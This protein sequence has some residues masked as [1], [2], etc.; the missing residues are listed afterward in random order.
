MNIPVELRKAILDND[1]V[2]FVGA[3][4]SYELTNTKNKPLK[5]WA[6]LV[7]CILEHLKIKGYEV[8]HLLPLIKRY[9]PIKVLDLIEHD[10]NLPKKEIYSFVKTFFELGD[11]NTLAIHKKIF[12]LSNK[13]ITT[14]YDTAFEEAVPQLRRNK[15]YKGKNY[16]LTTHK[17]KDS[18]LL[19]KLH[20]CSEDADSMVLFPTNYENLYENKERDAEHSLLVLK[21]IIL[22]KSILFIG[23]GLGDF[24][25]N[26]IFKEV[27]NLQ[28]EYNQKHFIITN[29]TL[30]SNLNFVTPIQIKA[31][32]EIDNIIDELISIKEKAKAEDTDEV[33]KL[34][35][36]LA[37]A[38]K[39]L[40]EPSNHSLKEELVKKNR[41]L[42]IEALKYFSKG[43]VFSISNEYL[44]ASSAYKSAI[45]LKPDYHEAFNNLGNALVNLGKS[46]SGKEAEGLYGQAITQYEK[47]I[48]LKPDYHE[49]FN[50]L[51][52][53]LGNLGKTK[54][55]KE[56][57][58]L[59]RQAI[60]KYENAITLKPDNHEAFN[61]LGN[62][63]GDLGKSKSG[64]EA[65]DLYRQAI[66]KIENAIALKPDFHEAFNNLGVALA[67]LGKSKSGKEAEDLY[68]QAITNYKKAIALKPDYHEAFINLGNAL[69]YLGQSKSGKEAE[70]LYRQSITKYDKAI[71]LKPDNHD[72]F[73]NL[74]TAL[75][76][77]GQ[78]KSDK[79]AED[80]Y[81]QA[82]A[83][84]EKAIEY[85]GSSYNLSCLYALRGDKN[86][87]LKYLAMSLSNNEIK[88][89][90]V[91]KDTDWSHYLYDK[92]FISVLNKFK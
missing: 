26:N 30:D 78:S 48:K 66:A 46:K 24:Q 84:Y 86:N 92:D 42:E 44:N 65:K 72:A 73:N 23:V 9:E 54:S 38:E 45:K 15:A 3:G 17:D 52:S 56:A 12:Q 63:L 80:L 55:G 19:F 8:E 51:G 33:K 25:I 90:F 16:E 41:L 49:A 71:A 83:E 43:I 76:Y 20:G 70:D 77:L 81:G 75:W 69:G 40:A 13:I 14:N 37:E 36:Q 21:N 85:G 57:E 53:A 28:K 39:K 47:A 22:N 31:F 10:K 87:A 64:K 88:V 2:I 79:E 1:L 29:Q 68:R 27:Q 62:A 74:G 82:I 34:K 4:L 61:N 67:Y 18:V 35:E 58:D 7:T 89:E 59:Y 5:G 50:N 32:S 60:A 11:K 91:E 6:N